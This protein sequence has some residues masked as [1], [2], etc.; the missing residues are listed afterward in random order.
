MTGNHN[1]ARSADVSILAAVPD[2]AAGGNVWR[3][4]TRWKRWSAG[5]MRRRAMFAARMR[6]GLLAASVA[7]GLGCST[8]G[9]SPRW[10][11]WRAPR[12]PRCRPYL[13]AARHGGRLGHPRGS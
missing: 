6:Q 7:I 1:L 12:L 11:S 9:S 5:S 8:S 2:D 3:L 4:P 13:P 10:S